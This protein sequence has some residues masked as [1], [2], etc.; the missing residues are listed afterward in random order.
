M[1]R[2][3]ERKHKHFDGA[4]V[5]TV[6]GHA[7]GRYAISV[8]CFAPDGRQLLMAVGTFGQSNY[9]SLAEAQRAADAEV[10]GL[11][12]ECSA[13]CEQWPRG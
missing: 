11:G 12:H 6:T 5:A 10:T 4:I 1:D 9:Q 2:V 8:R 3:Y 13:L 7:D